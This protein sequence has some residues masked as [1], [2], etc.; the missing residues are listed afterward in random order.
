MPASMV[1][2]EH[3]HILCI[4][5]RIYKNKLMLCSKKKFI[6]TARKIST[7]ANRYFELKV[8]P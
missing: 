3:V 6:G 7:A 4:L 5:H 8:P 1:L 2:K